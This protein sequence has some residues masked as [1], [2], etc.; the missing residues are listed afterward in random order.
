MPLTP[1]TPIDLPIVV[2]V[3]A[4]VLPGT[5]LQFNGT[6]SSSTPD[7]DA[8]NNT[9]NADTSVIANAD[10]VVSKTATPDPVLAGELVTY[11][12]V[13]TNNGPSFA[14]FV[15]LKDTLPAG[16]TQVGEATHQ[17][18]QGHATPS[19]AAAGSARRP[20]GEK[21]EVVTMT[22]V[23]RVGAGVQDGQRL[24]NTAT[25][26]SPSDVVSTTNNTAQAGVT[27]NR[28][29]ELQVSKRAHP[30]RRGAGRGVD[31]RDCGQ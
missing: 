5:S 22:V 1:D 10:L 18:Q 3:A 24:T 9:A 7:P 20:R 23:G 11:T 30:E 25:V 17:A 19:R 4:G 12:I 28:A 8:T 6:T 31:L 15:D 13:V 26:F 14:S 27:V 16:V 21:N 29:A 2:D